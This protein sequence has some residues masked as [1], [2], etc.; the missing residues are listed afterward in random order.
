[1]SSTLLLADPEISAKPEPAAN[2]ASAEL[3]PVDT[4]LDRPIT[5]RW[6]IKFSLP[7]ML[8]MLFMSTFTVID[9]IF[10]A[11]LIS[12]AAFAATNIVWP[13]AALVMAIG[14]M[15]SMGGSAVVAKLLG[16]NKRQEARGIF[17]MLTLVTLI[18]SAVIAAFGILFPDLLLNI[19]G[20]DEFLRAPAL[21]YLQPLLFMLPMAM[22]GFFIQQFFI[23][24]GKPNFG[25]V[26][27]LAGGLVNLGLN[28]LLI[29]HLDM[30]LRGAAISTT[31]GW[32]VPAV[33]GLV[34]FA[35]KTDAVLRFAK[36]IWDFRKLGRSA[37]NGASEMVT[38][39]AGSITGA[40][41]NNIL[42][43]LA[44]YEGVAA[45]GI[46]MVGQMVL[47]S[48]FLGYATGVAP[49]ISYL[50][51]RQDRVRMR[52]LFRRSLV[53]ILVAAAI[54]IVAGW[55]AAVPLSLIYVPAGT[56]IYAMAVAAFRFTLI[57]FLF[58]GING[59]ASIMFTAL[60]NGL[61]S[62]ALAFFRSLVFV[63]AMLA[64]LPALLGVN[65]VWLAL[66]AA[67]L[68]A[69]GMSIF[70]FMKMRRK[71]GYA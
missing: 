7:T 53:I 47:M 37:Y 21:E 60:S 56:P 49:I 32:S 16:E 14:F 64:V 70:F 31:I 23:T 43:R 11:R 26:S 2:S 20:V 54:S 42:I 68:L 12:P 25:F 33:I 28:F 10:A 8:G 63:L 19:L 46:M 1:M 57:G 13:F 38:M 58:M 45:V 18:G 27:A 51:G 34:Y 9:G 5:T 35:C 52:R 48:L 67:E 40:V 29:W 39:L 61:V 65:G 30:G 50:F 66:P 41:M 15:L 22:V 69:L 3:P 44:G 6:L 24:E 62:G 4:A 59:F 55:F 71:Y 36:P 17:T